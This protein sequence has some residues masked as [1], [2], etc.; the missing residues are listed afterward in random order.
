MD[1]ITVIAGVTLLIGVF[2][3]LRRTVWKRRRER[4]EIKASYMSG[5]RRSRP[6]RPGQL[7][8][9]WKG[10]ILLYNNSDHDAFKLRVYLSDRSES[11]VVELP[12]DDHLRRLEKAEIRVV[13]SKSYPM[14]KI[15]EG[16]MQHPSK[17]GEADELLTLKILVEYENRSGYTFYTLFTRHAGDRGM[18]ECSRGKPDGNWQLVHR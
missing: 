9:T 10:S 15:Q 18:S 12:M 2:E 5:R 7:S 17:S 3:L 6:G 16:D 8:C 13:V 1:A 11:L 4:P 14:E